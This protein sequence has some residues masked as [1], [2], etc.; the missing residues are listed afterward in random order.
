MKNTQAHA[1]RLGAWL[2]SGEGI[3]WLAAGTVLNPLYRVAFFYRFLACALCQY[4]YLIF[5]VFYFVIVFTLV[6][7]FCSCSSD[8]FLSSKPRTTG[9]LATTCRTFMGCFLDDLRAF[10][11]KVDQSVDDYSPGR[12]GMAQSGRTRGGIFH[13]EMDRCRENQGWTT[14]YAVV[15]PN[16]TG[17]TKKRIAQSRRA[18]AGSLA[19]MTIATSGANLYPPGVWFA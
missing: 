10:G 6:G 16:V 7:A 15:C 11:I 18:R 8:L 5:V 12:G 19:L 3:G 9:L 4:C 14:A 2:R 17:R 1:L 13:G